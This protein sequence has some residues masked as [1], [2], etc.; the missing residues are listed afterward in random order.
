MEC[1]AK[2]FA[3]RLDE[4]PIT[5]IRTI[6][7]TADLSLLLRALDERTA[8]RD[9][10]KEQ[11]EGEH[12]LVAREN[13]MAD[14]LQSVIDRG[15]VVEAERD[16]LQQWVH[17]LQAGMYINCVYCGHRYGPDDE[18]PA[19]MAQ[20]LKEHVEQCPKHPMSSLRVERDRLREALGAKDKPNKRKWSCVDG[21]HAFREAENGAP[22]VCGMAHLSIQIVDGFLAPKVATPTPEETTG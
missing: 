17:D 22:C 7:T 19:T 1:L 2:N 12:R 13:D 5:Y 9:A 6:G 8:E 3:A 20:A 4:L 18:V 21:T 16:K 10:L 11:L 14:M 15:I